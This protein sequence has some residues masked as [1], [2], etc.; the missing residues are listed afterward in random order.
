MLARIQQSVFSLAVVVGPGISQTGTAFIVDGSGLAVTNYHVIEGATEARAIIGGIATPIPVQL[1]AIK[2]EFD[3]ALVRL[4]MS[5]PL[6]KGK[7]LPPLQ[8]QSPSPAPGTEVWAIGFPSGLGLTVTRGVISGIRTFAQLPA[9]IRGSLRYDSTSQWLQTDCTLNHGNS[10]GPLVDPSGTVVGIATWHWPDATN[11]NFALGARH[12]ADFIAQPRAQ[13][14]SFASLKS[15]ATAVSGPRATFPWLDIKQDLSYSD[16]ARAA[17][18]FENQAACQVCKG[19]GVVTRKVVTGR[20]SDGNMSKPTTGAEA[21]TCPTCGG[22]YYARTDVIWSCGSRFVSR[23][24]RTSSEQL[25]TARPASL[26]G[27]ALQTVLSANPAILAERLN[28]RAV[29]LLTGPTAN[30]GEPVLCVGNVRK[31][32]SS[33]SGTVRSLVVALEG[34]QLVVIVVDPRLIDATERETVLVGGL[35]S[36]RL[37]GPDG[38]LVPVLQGGFVQSLKGK[39]G[40]S[41]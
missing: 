13:S 35:L 38:Q 17:K 22:Q 29:T 28:D 30:P 10:G 34:K 8:I 39:S 5:D 41:P 16:A 36:G 1:V 37:D 25:R 32:F 24:A 9:E 27:N 4:P 6:L 20:T 11:T 26:I 3:L 40:A 12:L 21:R 15:N 23:I 31:D 7:S 14:I 19:T 2:P 33:K 18:A